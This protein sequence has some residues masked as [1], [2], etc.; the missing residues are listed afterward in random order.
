VCMVKL[1]RF[2]GSL[3]DAPALRSPGVNPLLRQFELAHWHTDPYVEILIPWNVSLD[4]PHNF[5]VA[6][7]PLLIR[8]LIE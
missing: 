6:R 8:S 4:R 3:Q 1:S 2:R 5:R 7:N